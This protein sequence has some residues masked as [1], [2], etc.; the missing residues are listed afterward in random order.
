M[1]GYREM[2]VRIKP[3]YIICYGKPFS[4]MEGNIVV[5]DYYRAKKN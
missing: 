3:K 1:N 2:L 5:V 4:D